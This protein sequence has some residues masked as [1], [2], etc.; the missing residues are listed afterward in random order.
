MARLVSDLD[1][2]EVVLSYIDGYI[3]GDLDRLQGLGIT[4]L[5]IVTRTI[6]DLDGLYEGFDEVWALYLMTP[7]VRTVDFGRLAQLEHFRG[8]WYQIKGSVGAAAGLRRLWLL[9]YT[10]PDLV[11]LTGNQALKRVGTEDYPRISSF[12][13]L[14]GLPRLEALGVYVTRRLASGESWRVGVRRGSV[15]RVWVLAGR[16]ILWIGWLNIHRWRN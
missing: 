6:T 5:D 4:R 1:V 8:E 10:E 3:D 11:A 12:R 2:R 16:S 9:H 15:S 7:L 14:D 13:G